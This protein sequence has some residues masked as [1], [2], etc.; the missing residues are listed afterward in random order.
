[1]VESVQQGSFT[2]KTT[3]S[4]TAL[5]CSYGLLANTDLT[6]AFV[7]PNNRLPAPIDFL[8]VAAMSRSDWF[9]FDFYNHD[10]LLIVLKK[11]NN[12]PGFQ[13]YAVHLGPLFR[14]FCLEFYHTCI[15]TST[16]Y[17]TN[18]HHILYYIYYTLYLESKWQS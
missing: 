7:L 18:K 14:Y 9:T 2:T 17:K 10:L 11:K 15:Y 1:M 13:V 3:L 8:T 4:C 12:N 16:K 5:L 6:S